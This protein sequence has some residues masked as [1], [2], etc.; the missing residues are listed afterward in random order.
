MLWGGGPEANNPAAS[1]S[2]H[3]SYFSED[4]IVSCN[5][6]CGDHLSEKYGHRLEDAGKLVQYKKD[7]G[8]AA[9][10]SHQRHGLA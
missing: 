2:D 6:R 1:L 7:M 10:V 8:K 4:S 5:I 9:F 3:L